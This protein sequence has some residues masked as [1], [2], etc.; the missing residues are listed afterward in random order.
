MVGA[1]AADLGAAGAAAGLMA[2]VG[3]TDLGT[4]DAAA[5]FHVSEATLAGLAGA[6]GFAGAGGCEM[7]ALTGVLSFAVSFFGE[8]AARG[9]GALK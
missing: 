9:A 4:L 1:G 7:S 5:G 3:T 8:G 2:H 6:A